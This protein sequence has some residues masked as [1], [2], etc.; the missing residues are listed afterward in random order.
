M[1]AARPR[2]SAAAPG[3][4]PR[5][6]ALRNRALLI[7]TAAAAFRDEGLQVGVDEIARRARVGI[8]TLYRHFPT[9]GDLVVAVSSGLLD[10]LGEARDA[11]LAAGD[12]ALV[13][14][15]FL[16]AALAQLQ[17]N[18]GL[19]E[20]LAQH[21]PSPEIRERMRERMLEIVAPV[22]AR[23]HAAGTLERTLDAED[24]LI[25]IRML[26][27]ASAPGTRREPERY[28]RLL[29]AGLREGA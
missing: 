19:V 12:D 11:A 8:A 21:P 22:V 1:P 2:A 25:A 17:Q 13:L 10:Q 3:R 23:A 24:L 14:E 28:L 7:E 27:A 5:R 4:A 26:G 29:L 20:A 6:D 15:R 9:K 18:R 16:R